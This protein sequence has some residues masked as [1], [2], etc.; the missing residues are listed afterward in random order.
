[1]FDVGLAGLVFLRAAYSC[2][3][4]DERI[5][6]WAQGLI[7]HDERAFE[8]ARARFLRRPGAKR[9]HD[10][11]TNARRL[12]SLYED[13]HEAIPSLPS[14]RLRR[15][16]DLTGQARDAAVLRE[17][18]RATLDEHERHAARALLRALRKQERITLKRI[19]GALARQRSFTS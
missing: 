16:I 7:A 18:L 12:R 14:K 13:M 8:R 5:R 3:M 9:L 6:E 1:M 4:A 17:V 15:L 10:L 2:E 11:R 19:A